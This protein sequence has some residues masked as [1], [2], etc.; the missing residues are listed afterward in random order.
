MQSESRQHGV[1]Q[2][3]LVVLHIRLWQSVFVVQLVP[4]PVPVGVL[5]KY[6]QISTESFVMLIP[7]TSHAPKLRPLQLDSPQQ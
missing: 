3:W 1:V 5:P 6:V 2:V 7:T 4:N